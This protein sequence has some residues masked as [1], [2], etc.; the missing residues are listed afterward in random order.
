MLPA[1]SMTFKNAH[2]NMCDPSLLAVVQ[3]F[4]LIPHPKPVDSLSTDSKPR[5]MRDTATCCKPNEH[6]N[7]R[8]VNTP[9]LPRD[10]SDQLAPQPSYSLPTQYLSTACHTTVDRFQAQANA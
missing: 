4:L 7:A 2:G 5:R 8:P 6:G 3:M 9:H 1:T 10:R